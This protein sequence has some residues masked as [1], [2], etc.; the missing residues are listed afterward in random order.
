MGQDAAVGIM[1]GY[2]GGSANSSLSVSGLYSS[3][4]VSGQGPVSSEVVEFQ[5]IEDQTMFLWTTATNLTGSY[6]T[7]NF[8]APPQYELLVDSVRRKSIRLPGS[9]SGEIRVTLVRAGKRGPGNS[10]ALGEASMITWVTPSTNPE[11]RESKFPYVRFNLGLGSNGEPLPTLN[12]PLVP[13]AAAFPSGWIVPE[14]EGINYTTDGSQF[15]ISTPQVWVKLE[16]DS[17]NPGWFYLKFMTPGTSDVFVSYHFQFPTY[18]YPSNWYQGTDF[19][20]RIVKSINGGLS[21]ETKISGNT[22]DWPWSIEDWRI[23]ETTA[24]RTITGVKEVQWPQAPS[25]PPG[26]GIYTNPTLFGYII[27]TKH[28]GVVT[29]RVRYDY[30]AR[31]LQYLDENDNLIEFSKILPKKVTEGYQFPNESYETSYINSFYMSDVSGFVKPDG[32]VHVEYGTDFLADDKRTLDAWLDNVPTFDDDNPVQTLPQANGSLK[33]EYTYDRSPAFFSFG[34]PT[35]IKKIETGSNAVVAYS[36]IE[37]SETT[38]MANEPAVVSAVRRDFPATGGTPVVTTTKHYRLDGA[39]PVRRGRIYSLQ[40]S[41]GAK[42]SFAYELG[43]F[44]GSSDGSDLKITVLN[45]ASSGGNVV[46]GIP[47]V[48]G[49]VP[50]TRVVDSIRLHPNKSTKEAQVFKRGFLVLKETHVYTGGSGNSPV[51][52]LLNS[53]VFDYTS[54]GRLKSRIDLNGSTYLATWVGSLKTYEEDETGLKTAFT[55]DS[56]DRGASHTTSAGGALPAQRLAFSYD[57]AN[58]I[59]LAKAGPVGSEIVTETRYDAGGRIKKKIMPGNTTID[60]TYQLGGRQVT[61]TYNLGTS[62]EATKVTLAYKDGRPKSVTGI[63][64]VNEF[65]SYAVE[66]GKLKTA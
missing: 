41:S 51:F 33:T 5:L 50:G 57:G 9:F 53:Q 58:R 26:S 60:Y 32:A 6:Y 36:E 31:A 12:L 62:A 59:L 56:M 61:E 65:R 25:F 4:A 23:A 18:T 8:S 35:L 46:S 43:S 48:I 15:E 39:D 63:A 29:S 40:L 28:A 24:V 66:G 52:Q 10:Q 37:Y 17:A 14:A 44:A 22:R 11:P 49:G 1:I 19:T 16:H 42:Q 7:I 13:R 30:Q 47:V 2:E 20:A 38:P 64:V 54:D 55:Y 45:G 3:P 34:W 27:E 21:Y